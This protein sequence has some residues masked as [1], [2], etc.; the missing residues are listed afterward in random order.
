MFSLW[1]KLGF[2]FGGL[3]ILLLV[4]GWYSIEQ[5]TEL[6]PSIDVIMRENYQ[7]VAACQQMKESLER[8]DSGVLF[9][10]SGYPEQGTELIQ[11]NKPLFLHALETELKNITLPGEGEQAKEIQRLFKEYS[12]KLSRFQQSRIN[13]KDE[14]KLYFT[15]LLPLFQK[16]KTASNAILQM[17]HENMLVANTNARMRAK[18]A[19]QRMLVLVVCGVIVA[20]GFIGFIGKWIRYPLQRLTTSAGEIARGNLD[21]VVDIHSRDELGQ[22]AEMFNRMTAKL[23]EFRRDD[24]ARI[25][26]LQRT[27]QLAVDSFP[28]A[29][30]V[31]SP[32][33]R[34]E[35]ANRLAVSLFDLRP[36][37]RPDFM[38]YSWLSNLLKEVKTQRV[39]PPR[40]YESAIQVFD[41]NEEKFF[42][43][44]AVGIYDEGHDLVG[45]TVILSDVTSLRKID[46]MKSG[47]LSTV[48]HEL[49]T[50]LTSLR[51]AIYLLLEE[52]VGPVNAKQSELLMGARDDADRLVTIIGNLL[53]MS[54][55]EA[56]RIQMDF[57]SVAVPSFVD[58]VISPLR[59]AFEDRG[60]TL[61]VQV[62]SDIE[63]VWADPVRIRLVMGNLLS[64]ALKYTPSGGSVTVK[65]YKKEENVCFSVADTG[66]GIPEEYRSRIFD[67]FFRVPDT[68]METQGAG[69]GLAIAREL[70]KV[71]GGEIWVESTVGKGSTFYF[72]LPTAKTNHK[73]GSSNVG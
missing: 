30:A 53:D 45:I 47:L 40:G 8:L 31:L 17:N 72:T 70:V 59:A 65:V 4:T 61:D 16:I 38:K 18:E 49:N 9:I 60:I 28:D 41:N 5:I 69:L 64:N 25:I 11:T 55:F 44:K 57:Q 10:L 27:T 51:M 26:R 3:M 12:E 34:I 33:G 43:P 35:L 23:R 20:V 42:L 24:N 54:R 21:L 56:G 19:R 52:K 66:V 22:L 50:P 15:H 36:M 71:H 14:G 58:S 32:D 48:S 68:G 46:E 7:S 63:D 2:G 67:K 39:N 62:D 29:I 13:F 37:E 6:G 73:G 1:H